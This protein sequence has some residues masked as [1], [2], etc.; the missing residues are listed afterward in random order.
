MDISVG[1]F[2]LNNLFSRFN[3][4]GVID[5]IKTGDTDVSV[6]AKYDFTDP[7]TFKIRTFKGKLVKGKDPKDTDTIARRIVEMNLDVLGCQEVEDVDTL[8]RF[9]TDNLKGLYPFQ[10]LVEGNDNRLIDVAVLSKLPIGAVTSWQKAVHPAVP[11]EPVFSRDLLQVEILN[12]SRTKRLFT[13]F[14]NHLKSRFV[15]PLE[16]QVIGTKKANELRQRQ[17]EMAAQII[18]AQLRPTSSFMVLGDMNDPP[19]SPL[20]A[21][22][23]SS[24]TMKLHNALEKPTETRPVK[25]S[26]DPPKNTAWTD[27]F[28]KSGQ[29]AD[30]LLFD[31]IWLS[32]PL[33][34]KQTGAF[35]DRRKNLTGDGSDHDP[36]WVTLTV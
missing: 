1:T 31:Q 35:I 4:S 8:R 33:A 17:A 23:V 24:S 27:R 2:N 18:E 16:N 30:Y 34:S 32:P 29:P 3:F 7:S 26:A 20:L 14:V 10:V 9:N 13:M 5:A 25:P 12:G 22:L 21:P 19:E 36:A 6:S 11:T 15:D 28:K